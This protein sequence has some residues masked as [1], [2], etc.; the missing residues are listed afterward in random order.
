M[1]RGKKPRWVRDLAKKRI[2]ILLN[3]A[4]ENAKKKPKRSKRY[5]ELARKISKKYNVSIS[6]VSKD[7]KKKICKKCNAIWIQGLNVKVRTD[8]KTKTIQYI[9]Q[10]CGYVKRYGYKKTKKT[11]SS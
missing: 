1:K 5:V 9:C 10:E 6:S 8:S 11:R 2:K 4:E 7:W 3:L